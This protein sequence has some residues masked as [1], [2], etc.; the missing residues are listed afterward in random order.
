MTEQREGRM[1]DS[2]IP[3][4][5]HTTARPFPPVVRRIFPLQ[6]APCYHP[7]G[8]ENVITRLPRVFVSFSAAWFPR[9]DPVFLHNFFNVVPCQDLTPSNGP[10]WSAF[11]LHNQPLLEFSL[12]LY[13][14]HSCVPERKG[15]CFSFTAIKT[16]RDRQCAGRAQG[17]CSA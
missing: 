6:T 14:R 17:G 13:F 1:A 3:P 16:G 12:I 11:F 5:F 8:T 15:A 2:T 4:R 7:D 9:R 10:F